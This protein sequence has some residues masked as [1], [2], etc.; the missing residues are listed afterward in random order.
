MYRTLNQ[1]FFKTWSSEMAYVLG[2]F[3]ADGNMIK[4]KRGAHFIA[5]YRTDKDIIE[6]IK[7]LLKSSHKISAKDRRIENP[8]WKLA[9]QLQIG[10]KEVFD[11][12]TK[13][14]MTPNKS[15]TI[16]MPKVPIQFLSHFLRGYF[17][18]FSTRDSLRLYNYMYKQDR[19]LCLDRKKVIFQ[20]YFNNLGA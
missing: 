17:V 10:S 8:K 1:D 15:L 19:D 11:D 6:K 2:F 16:R 7:F 4:N 20:Q 18:C 14:G 3:V 13:L 5:F 12:L 9:Y